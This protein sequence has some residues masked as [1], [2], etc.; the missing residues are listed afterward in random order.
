MA[1]LNSLTL[2]QLIFSRITLISFVDKLKDKLGGAES[3]PRT[4]KFSLTEV[5]KLGYITCDL[6]LVKKSW[7]Q[8]ECGWAQTLWVLLNL[9]YKH[10]LVDL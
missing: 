10:S 7:L 2:T 5:G 3:N 1:A 8:A 4:V 9:D 6:N